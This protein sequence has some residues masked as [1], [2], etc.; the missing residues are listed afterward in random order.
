[1]KEELLTCSFSPALYSAA[2]VLT[3]HCGNVDVHDIDERGI[4]NRL[5][6]RQ[7]RSVQC[8]SCVQPCC[9]HVTRK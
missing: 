6:A 7:G 8:V 2:A 9:V 4:N 1:M 5:R 3:S